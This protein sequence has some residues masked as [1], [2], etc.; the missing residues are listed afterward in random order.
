[1]I[2]LQ[3]QQDVHTEMKT[4]GPL[5]QYITEVMISNAS[6][7]SKHSKQLLKYGQI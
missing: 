4:S 2:V 6:L 5:H 3:G 1:M 7:V